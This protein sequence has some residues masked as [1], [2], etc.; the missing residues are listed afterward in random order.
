MGKHGAR[1]IGVKQ[2]LT[3]KKATTAALMRVK[4]GRWRIKGSFGLT[5]VACTLKEGLKGVSTGEYRFGEPGIH[6]YARELC[7]G[8]D[9]LRIIMQ[10]YAY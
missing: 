5:K 2:L 9:G 1:W 6:D 8:N 4:K 10:L 3:L 7:P